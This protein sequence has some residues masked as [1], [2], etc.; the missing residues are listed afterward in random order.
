[1]LLRLHIITLLLMRKITRLT[2]LALATL[3]CFGASAV[4]FKINVANPE[5]V[6]LT[7]N[8]NG[9]STVAELVA[10]DNSFD[11]PEYAYLSAEGVSPWVIESVTNQFGTPESVYSGMWYKT[12]YSSDEGATYTIT[13]KNLEEARTA[14]CTVNVDDAS[15][16][17]ASLSGTNS[18][19]TFVNGE[20]T[21]R[22]DPENETTLR[23]SAANYNYPLYSVTVNGESVGSEYGSY[24]VPLTQGCE[25]NI[26]AI[27]PDK[28]ITLTIE[29]AD[30][31]SVGAIGQVRVEDEIVT[32]VD[33]VV[34]LKAGQKIGILGNSMYNIESAELNGDPISY[35]SGSYEYTWTA[36]DNC[37]LKVKAHKYSTFNVKV[38]VNDPDQITLYRGSSYSGDV[39][40]L[41]EGEN[42]VE[43]PEN[44]SYITWEIAT[45]CKLVSAT[46][47]GEATTA[48]GVYATD[49]MEIV[50]E[51]AAI[52][53]DKTAVVWTDFDP[54]S[55]TYF[56]FSTYTRDD[57]GKN[58]SQG[59]NVVPF[60][61]AYVPFGLSWYTQ[62]LD[63][64]KVYVNDEIKE[65]QYEGST[66]YEL[67][68]E[69]G[70]VVKVFLA[71]EPVECAVTF[72]V[73]EGVE[74]NVTRDVIKPVDDLET[75]LT[76]FAGTQLNITSETENVIVLVNDKK[77][78]PSEEAGY[79]FVVTEPVNVV[80]KVDGSIGITTIGAEAPAAPVYN[81][82]GVR[83][84]NS[85]DA[86]PAGIYIQGGK[87]VVVK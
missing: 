15:R 47:N 62:E 54:Q 4:N 72:E 17:T 9:S 71:A 39:I 46:I 63:V 20:N 30:E 38:T 2:A 36:M 7:V 19:V 51:T 33:N 48:Q 25:V 52:F 66:S 57:L 56:S 65:P 58:F 13:T 16:V 23:L 77:V 85:L 1:M 45:G 22:F 82:Q 50:F 74:A 86:L 8:A 55:L 41:N 18:D 75:P 64:N 69:N 11:L 40:E 59:Y 5:S 14:S 26:I 6:K 35:W 78:T 67:P 43:V 24:Y 28:D 32:P 34:T 81:L 87:K 53:M 49:N 31:A 84:S 61:D 80:M 73:E 10:G 12:V 60:Y 76:V 83:V 79:E 68:L 44:N 29:Y 21:L 70:D 37:V 42:T 27:I 3:T